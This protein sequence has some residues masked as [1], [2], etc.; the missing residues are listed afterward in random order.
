MPHIRYAICLKKLAELWI[1]SLM[2]PSESYDPDWATVR[3]SYHHLV[4][5]GVCPYLVIEKIHL[6]RMLSNLVHNRC[7]IQSSYFN[8]ETACWVC[9]YTWHS[10]LFLLIKMAAPIV[11]EWKLEWYVWPIHPPFKREWSKVRRCVSWRTAIS[12]LRW[13]KWENPFTFHWV[14]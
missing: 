6:W 9:L 7:I 4:L 10:E 12:T 13:F 3:N 1:L 14:I 11:L 8:N 5:G 2:I